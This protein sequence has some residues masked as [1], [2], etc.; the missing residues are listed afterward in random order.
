MPRLPSSIPSPY[1]NLNLSSSAGPWLNF[2]VDLGRCLWAILPATFLW[3]ASFPLAIAA[4]SPPGTNLAGQ[5]LAEQD[6]GRLVGETY[7]ANTVGAIAGALAFSMLLIPWLGTQQSQRVLI[8]VSLVA[9]LIAL[10]PL[11][12]PFARGLAIAGASTAV[13]MALAWSVPQI[14]WLMIGYGRRM[15]TQTDGGHLL[16]FAEGMNSSMAVSE[17]P[18]GQHYFHVSGK[19]EASTEPFDMRLQRMLGHLPALIHPRPRSVLIV[20]FGAGLC[21]TRSNTRTPF[22]CNY[23]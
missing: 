20:G 10:A 8:A 16:Y 14:P 22:S 6:L 19:V 12:R 18:G 13:A 5:G 1:W 4:V 2:A 9:G 17:L 15:T 23:C 21:W 7:A 3:G 11:L